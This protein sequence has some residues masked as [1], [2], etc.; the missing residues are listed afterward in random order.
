[1]KLI[2]LNLWAGVVYEPLIEFIKKH[3]EDTDVFCFQEMAFGDS[4]NFTPIYKARVNLF[5]N[6][7]K[8]FLILF[9]LSMFLKVTIFKMNR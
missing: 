9:L 7:L 2:T 1:M 8:Y 4:P 5:L 6:F 3:S